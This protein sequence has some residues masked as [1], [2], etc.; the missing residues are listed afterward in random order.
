MTPISQLIV[1]Q[2]SNLLHL[3]KNRINGICRR[4][5]PQ[6]IVLSEIYV[7]CLWLCFPEWPV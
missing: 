3:L 1:L 2:T 6:R 5:P 7:W 4:R